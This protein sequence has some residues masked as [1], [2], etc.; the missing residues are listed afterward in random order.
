MKIFDL[1][2]TL[3]SNSDGYHICLKPSD[4]LISDYICTWKLFESEPSNDDINSFINEM[5]PLLFNDFKSMD[6]IPNE[7][8]NEFILY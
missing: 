7:I 3:T 2:Y 5:K 4:I 8:K 6:N 1:T